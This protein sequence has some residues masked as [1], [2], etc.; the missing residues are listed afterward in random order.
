LLA[1]CLSRW[2]HLAILLAVSLRVTPGS[3]DP[4]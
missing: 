1:R 4:W 2:D 3:I